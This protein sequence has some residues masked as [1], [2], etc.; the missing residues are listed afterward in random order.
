M[1]VIVTGGAGFIGSHL[2]EKLVK[3]GL[4]VIVFDNFSSGK[5]EFLNNVKCEI[6]KGDIINLKEV[7]DV[8][9]GVD[10][11]Y[12]L[13]A[14]PDVRKSVLNPLKNFEIDVVGTLNVLEACRMNDVEHI[15]FTSSSTVYGNAK[16]LPTPE[17]ASIIPVSNYG[18]AKATSENYVMSFSKLYGIH[19]IILRY[20][21]IIGP[22]L[23]HGVIYDFYKKLKK[24]PKELEILGDGEQNKSYL[25][26][27]D[28]VEA[29]I[30]TVNAAKKPFDIFNI[31]SE[32]QVIV[33]EIANIIVSELGLRDVS[34]KY[35]G[36]KTGWKGDV[37]SMLLSIDKMKRIGWRP[38]RSTKEAVIDTINWLKTCLHD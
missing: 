38:K 31:G 22:R 35:T 8:C 25:H 14:D 23:T 26:V 13:A 1:K 11:V 18:A 10:V 4:K 21:N 37:P 16:K 5:K 28:C 12:H 6:V 32:E 15:V 20:A 24:N 27:D 33:K 34:Y 36:G 30:S 17:N 9:K 7:I 3:E 2:T 19:G 29:T